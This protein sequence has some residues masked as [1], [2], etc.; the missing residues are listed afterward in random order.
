MLA[1]HPRGNMTTLHPFYHPQT[2]GL[3]L[4]LYLLLTYYGFYVAHS[5]IIG[6]LAFISC[7]VIYHFMRVRVEPIACGIGLRWL[8][9]SFTIAW[10]SIASVEMRRIP[11]GDGLVLLLAS[12]ETVTIGG[13]PKGLEE[14]IKQNHASTVSEGTIDRRLPWWARRAW[15]GPRSP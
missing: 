3:A 1:N 8:W 12:G 14:F 7:P 11:F 13:P 9:L 5:G 6:L 15:S 4:L 2:A 10:P